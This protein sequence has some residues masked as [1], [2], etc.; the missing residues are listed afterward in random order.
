LA[1]LN[2]GIGLGTFLAV[3]MVVLL[4]ERYRWIEIE[5]EIVVS[6]NLGR[7]RDGCHLPMTD[8]VRRLREFFGLSRVSTST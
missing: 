6:D 4:P 1:G 7:H 8:A 3:K 5:T 2:I